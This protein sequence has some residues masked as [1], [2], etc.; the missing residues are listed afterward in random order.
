MLLRSQQD[1]LT[2]G[3]AAAI[4]I[5][6]RFNLMSEWNGQ[7]NAQNFPSPGGEDRGQVRLGFQV[8][9]GGVRWDAAAVAGLT[10]RD[11]RAGVVFGVTKEFSLWK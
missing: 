4:P 3:L 1:V 7:E 2:Y 6:P 8:R 10:R 5:G 11:P 9:A